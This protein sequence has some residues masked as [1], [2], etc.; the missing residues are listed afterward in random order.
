MDN[1][2]SHESRTYEVNGASAQVDVSSELV[3]KGLIAKQ[4]EVVLGVKPGHGIVPQIPDTPAT[5]EPFEW[6]ERWRNE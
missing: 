4:G 1:K 5:V 3:E 6:S 2:P